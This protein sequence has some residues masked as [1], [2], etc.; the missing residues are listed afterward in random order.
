MSIPVPLAEQ[1]TPLTASV[2]PW[3]KHG[4]TR[5]P[6]PSQMLWDP[7]MERKPFYASASPFGGGTDSARAQDPPVSPARASTDIPSPGTLRTTQP[8]Q[9]GGRGA[10]RG[11]T[12]WR[13]ST[14][15]RAVPRVEAGSWSCRAEGWGIQV[16]RKGLRKAGGR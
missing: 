12:R 3:I 16:M 7:L 11:A 2:S 8:R 1:H 10:P 9:R 14:G 13:P 15:L 5:P 4:V 6:W